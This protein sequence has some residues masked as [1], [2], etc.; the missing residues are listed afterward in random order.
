MLVI[1]VFLQSVRLMNGETYELLAVVTTEDVY[2][3]HTITY[4]AL[5]PNKVRTVLFRPVVV[6]KV[7]A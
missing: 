2:G 6:N 7:V 5:Y 3:W 1:I 4:L